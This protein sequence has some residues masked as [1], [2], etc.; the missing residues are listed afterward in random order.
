MMTMTP[1]ILSPS[2]FI[3]SCLTSRVTS[4]CLVPNPGSERLIICATF[5]HSHL[6]DEFSFDRTFVTG[7][8]IDTVF[9]IDDIFPSVTTRR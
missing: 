5:L 8:R 3:A 6:L 2:S 7:I 9:T 4:S 1:N